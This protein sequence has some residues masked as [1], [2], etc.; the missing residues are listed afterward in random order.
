MNGVSL[1]AIYIEGTAHFTHVTVKEDI[2]ST[3]TVLENLG[4]TTIV[5]SIFVDLADAG[6][7][8]NG[9]NVTVTASLISDGSCGIV[10][11]VDGNLSGYAGVSSFVTD[12]GGLTPT[13]RLRSD[14]PAIDVARRDACPQIDQRWYERPQGVGCDMGA[15]E[16]DAEPYSQHLMPIV[17]A[18]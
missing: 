16:Y 7:V 14:S 9:E 3:D 11:G 17:F 15:F 8:C 13:L 4:E 18:R 1:S 6:T 10:D 12:A 5:N 2:E